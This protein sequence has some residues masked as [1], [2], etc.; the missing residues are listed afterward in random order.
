[1][2]E[3]CTIF[4]MI[5][6]FSVQEVKESFTTRCEVTGNYE[7]WSLLHVPEASIFHLLNQSSKNTLY[8]WK[9][10]CEIF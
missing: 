1:M 8:L 4:V 6:H 10:V 9:S 7:E 3:L 5:F 2:L